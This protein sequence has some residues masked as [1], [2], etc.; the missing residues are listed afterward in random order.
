MSD[1]TVS[2][3][4][5]SRPYGAERSLAFG[6]GL[7]GL[8]AGVL[9]LVVGFGW[10]GTYRAGRPVVDPLAVDWLSAQPVL[11]RS[12]AVAAGVLLFAGGLWFLLRCLRPEGRPDIRLDTSVGREL[13]VTAGAIASAV[14][15]DAES[16]EGVGRARVRAVGDPD[17]PALR[18]ELWL[19]EGADLLRIWQQL[20]A[21]V[22]ARA[23]ES[24]EREV[25][26]TAIRLE[27]GAAQRRRV[28]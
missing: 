12:V 1:R 27:L 18:I 3:R 22:L 24:L 23:R 17:S 19:R 5:L 20:D 28:R 2:A 16:V 10:L 7:L 21:D 26:P 6:I 11:A 25:L 14:R 13:T 9:A 8:A 15:A 4:A